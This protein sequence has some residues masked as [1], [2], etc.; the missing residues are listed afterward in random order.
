MGTSNFPLRRSAMTSTRRI[1][2]H[3]PPR[4]PRARATGAGGVRVRACAAAALGLC[5]GLA[6]GA[7]ILVGAPAVGGGSRADAAR[8]GE[9]DSASDR[10]AVPV[11]SVIEPRR[12][13]QSAN[14]DP[15]TASP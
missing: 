3:Q 5:S 7:A 8:P 12:H 4:A 15:E 10:G 6:L 11:A 2:R 13:A 14:M 1:A 9:S